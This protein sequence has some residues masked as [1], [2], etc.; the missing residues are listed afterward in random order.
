M[1]IVERTYPVYV[2]SVLM[3]DYAV[4]ACMMCLKQSSISLCRFACFN[5]YGVSD[6]PD[7][8]IICDSMLKKFVC[9]LITHARPLPYYIAWGVL[10]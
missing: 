4:I 9:F 6:T 1:T 3:G 2:T 10:L 7:S 5:S 8:R